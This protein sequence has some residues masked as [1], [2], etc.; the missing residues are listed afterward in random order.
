MLRR[1][2]G[3]ALRLLPVFVMIAA[4]SPVS[5]ENGS[6]LFDG[7]DDYVN[8]P[9]P[10]DLHG[11]LT[12]ETWVKAD[13]LL[14]VGRILSNRTGA[15]GYEMDIYGHDGVHTL[16]FTFNGSLVH[17]A[18]FTSHVGVWTHVAAL[19]EGPPNGAVRIY[20]NGEL[21]GAEV[22][23]SSIAASSGPFRIGSSGSGG[24]HFRGQIDEVRIWSAAVSG[25]TIASW[26]SRPVTA[27]HPDYG[28]LE[29]YWNFDEGSGQVVHN[30]VGDARRD[31]ELGSSSGADANDPQWQP[32]GA[33][34][35]VEPAT[36]GQIKQ[37]F[38]KP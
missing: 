15:N 8:V 17:Q 11:P 21:P 4:A 32:D 35:P 1:F 31:G 16:R 6:L 26:M 37:R 7:T 2:S 23:S 9:E 33:P 10:I 25:A 28:N 3:H 18:D 30:L 13:A 24:F 20:I 29:A 38:L 36:V 34:V 14:S 12:V 22:F 27:E 5:A 19:W